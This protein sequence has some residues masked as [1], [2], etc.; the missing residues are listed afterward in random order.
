MNY[1]GVLKKL[2]TPVSVQK[3]QNLDETT[4]EGLTTKNYIA[5]RDFYSSGPGGNV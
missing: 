4:I 3:T 5:I 1:D 2:Q